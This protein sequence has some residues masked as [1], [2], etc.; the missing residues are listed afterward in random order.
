MEVG[1]CGSFIFSAAR[2]GDIQ[3]LEG[4]YVYCD[5]HSLIKSVLTKFKGPRRI[6]AWH[7]ILAYSTALALLASLLWFA[8]WQ[9]RHD[10]PAI[11]PQSMPLQDSDRRTEG[12]AR[13][14]TQPLVAPTSE[15][16]SLPSTPIP[17]SSEQ[18]HTSA[19]SEEPTEVLN[20]QA[21]QRLVTR[22][23]EARSN[24][25]EHLDARAMD[26]LLARL[27]SAD[28]TGSPPSPRAKVVRKRG[29]RVLPRAGDH[30]APG[31]VSPLRDDPAPLS[32][33][34]GTP[35]PTAAR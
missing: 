11:V 10:G 34:A 27:E 8:P 5:F 29:V 28:K 25:A 16:G 20:T 15:A 7:G 6:Q 1:L 35:F 2:I 24:P 22:L 17:Q 33:A 9:G 32:A 21:M 13:P 26:R 12:A 31:S 23:D 14:T 4:L 19:T 18:P 3:A 30:G